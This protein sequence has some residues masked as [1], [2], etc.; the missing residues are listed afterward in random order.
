MTRRILVLFGA[1]MVL[2]LLAVGAGAATTARAEG[3]ATV[4]PASGSVND[5]FTFSV[6]GLTPGNTVRI[7]IIDDA[8]STFQL[9]DSSGNPLVL[10]VQDDGTV[11][12]TLTPA[13]DTPSAQPG[14]WSAT[15][16]E[17][18]TGANTSINFTVSS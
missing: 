3:V 1:V 6:S 16:E 15:F 13:V 9:S 2:V 10:I 11:T 5:Q 7:Q 4:S 12:D 18:E 8:G 14:N 17:I